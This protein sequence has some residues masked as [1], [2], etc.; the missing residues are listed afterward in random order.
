MIICMCRNI[1]DTDFGTAEDLHNRIME[2]D[3]VCGCCQEYINETAKNG[4]DENSLV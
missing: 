1:R 4:I 3:A 2:C